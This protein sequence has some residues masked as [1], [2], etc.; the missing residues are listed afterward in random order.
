MYG[1]KQSEPG[2]GPV[3]SDVGRLCVLNTSS[4]APCWLLQLTW[5]VSLNGQMHPQCLIEREILAGFGLGLIC[6]NSTGMFLFGSL[7]FFSF[8]LVK[9]SD[10][11]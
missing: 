10:L 11:I 5:G 8:N 3:S 7:F 6:V 2:T 1:S 9:V 4:V